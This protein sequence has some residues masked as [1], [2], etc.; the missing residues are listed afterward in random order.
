MERAGDGALRPIWNGYLSF[1]PPG[2]FHRSAI[3]DEPAQLVAKPLVVEHE[4]SDLC[5][6]AGRAAT[7][8]PGDQRRHARLREPPRGQP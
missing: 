1:L 2:Q 6:E 8:T 4:L 3:E 7:R 5:R